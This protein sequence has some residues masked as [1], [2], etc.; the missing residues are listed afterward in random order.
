[1]SA[2]ELDALASAQIHHRANAHRAVAFA[3]AELR[4]YLH[5]MTGVDIPIHNR[6]EVGGRTT[7][8]LGLSPVPPASPR[9]P[10]RG[11]YAIR[12]QPRQVSLFGG[13]PRALLDA[14]YALLEQL[15]CVWSLHER[16]EEHVPDHRGAG[17]VEI[18][19][20]VHTPPFR[21]RGYCSDIMTWHYTQPEYFHERLP[22]DRQLIDWMGKS[23]ATTFFYIR[24]PFDT[25]LAIPELSED[26]A[27]RAID[28]EYGGHVIPLLLPRETFAERP[29]MFPQA[30]DGARVELGNLCASNVDGLAR[31]AANASAY[32]EQYPEMSAL[33][34]WG[35]DLWEGGWCH[36][37]GCSA[38]TVQDQSL[39]VCNAVAAGLAEAGH[40][41]PVCYLAYH[42]TLEARLS[43][44]ADP[45]VVCEWAPRER[46]YGHALDD[47]SCE[48]NCRYR[49][50]LEKHVEWFDGRV[51]LFEY[52]G[53]AILYFGCALPLAEVIAADMEYYRR[54]G[55]REA[56]MLQ[57]GAYSAWAHP[58]SFLAF[59]AA[60]QTA[61]VPAARLRR[62]YCTRFGRDAALAAASLATMEQG[63]A[64]VARY[65]DIRIAPRD[66]AVAAS[67]RAAIAATLPRL[68][69]VVEVLSGSRAE[70]LRA[71]ADLV[72][73]TMLVLEGV[74]QDIAERGSGSA[75]F[76]R[77]L[78]LAENCDRRFKGSWGAVDLP[79]IHSFYSAAAAMAWGGAD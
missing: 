36:C 65:G 44:R 66:P 20:A 76:A 31:A 13:S 32:V 59:A 77:A 26:L 56:L 53:D 61:V 7:L 67:T 75:L 6:A 55:I 12:A 5:R 1:M 79:I 37:S 57:F 52:Y 62:L 70:A 8:T 29:D 33:H 47:A 3:A 4:T 50:S 24:H 30:A 38:L 25:Q 34:I 68:H 23:G 11:S 9:L 16:S 46:C 48:R 64:A 58:L 18:V 43:V 54:L 21:L 10:E 28:V 42:D 41:R 2:L 40:S 35:A 51:R 72:R 74:E 78:T 27:Q 71:Q 73:Y 69:E 22:E 39:R 19:D 45:Q 60:T 49:V 15:G 14:T 17:A 63:M